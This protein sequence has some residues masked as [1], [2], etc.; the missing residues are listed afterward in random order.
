ML[1]ATRIDSSKSRTSAADVTTTTFRPLFLLSLTVLLCTA[2]PA[3]AYIDPGAAGV[4]FQVGYALVALVAA[5][6][7]GVRNFVYGIFFKKRQ[8]GSAESTTDSLKD[9]A[10]TQD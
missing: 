2:K 10:N 6:L 3:Y 7:L 5:Y 9:S 4:L 8:N 1:S